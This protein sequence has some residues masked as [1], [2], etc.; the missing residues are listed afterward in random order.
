MHTYKYI[1]AYMHIHTYTFIRNCIYTH[2]E[3]NDAEEKYKI[4]TLVP[5]CVF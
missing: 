3:I 1:H 2:A 5:V 4:R